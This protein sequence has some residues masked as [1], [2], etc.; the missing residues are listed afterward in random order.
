MT[1]TI[2]VQSH[3]FPALVTVVDEYAGAKTVAD[4][5]L[6]W[7]EDGVRTFHCTTSRTVRVVDLTYEEA[8][9]RFPDRPK[10]ASE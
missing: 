6:L 5:V 1:T 3:N 7:P 2:T 8:A 9:Q 10:P 4:E